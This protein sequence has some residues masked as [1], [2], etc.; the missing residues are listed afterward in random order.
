MRAWPIVVLWQLRLLAVDGARAVLG[1]GDR[2]AARWAGVGA[3]VGAWREF[4]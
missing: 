2:S 4:A 3:A 1:R